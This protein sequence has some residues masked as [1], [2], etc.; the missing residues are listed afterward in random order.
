MGF[1]KNH[2]RLQP[3]EE[4]DTEFYKKALSMIS[5]KS[6]VIQS[7]KELNDMNIRLSAFIREHSEF[8]N[9]GWKSDNNKVLNIT[10]DMDVGPI[11]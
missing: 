4:E 6:P 3:I 7:Q 11:K 2:V 8:Y 9:P 5:S 1:W 10:P